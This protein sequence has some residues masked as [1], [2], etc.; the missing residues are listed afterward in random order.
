MEDIQPGQV[1]WSGI[2]NRDPTPPSEFWPPPQTDFPISPRGSVVV[3][4]DV[5]TAGLPRREAY[6]MSM[7]STAMSS[8]IDHESTRLDSLRRFLDRGIGVDAIRNGLWTSRNTSMVSSPRSPVTS[9]PQPLLDLNDE[10]SGYDSGSVD[11]DE[12]SLLE[13]LRASPT[14][15][16]SYLLRKPSGETEIVPENFLKRQFNEKRPECRD[17]QEACVIVRCFENCPQ[18]VTH[19][20]RSISMAERKWE[21]LCQVTKWRQSR[22]RHLSNYK[23]KSG[24]EPYEGT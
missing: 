11:S 6:V 17:T 3:G 24:L 19:M 8:Q 4:A 1:R 13:M 12:V 7:H 10:K 21:N 16:R 18:L 23:R 9:Q 15:D 14:Q 22:T 20:Y 2:P 5:T